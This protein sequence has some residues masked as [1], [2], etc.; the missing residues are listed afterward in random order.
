[1]GLGAGLQL[2]EICN[3]K[4]DDVMVSGK[5][6][7]VIQVGPKE[8]GRQV[9]ISA[10]SRIYLEKHLQTLDTTKP[11]QLVFFSPTDP[12]RP[13][14]TPSLTNMFHRLFKNLEM[15]N[16]SFYSL[17][18]THAV[19]LRKMGIDK[20]IIRNQLGIRRARALDNYLDASP[21]S[22]E[23]AIEFLRF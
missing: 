11:E 21:E 15:P 4:L 6:K 5:V 10:Q 18:K 7:R 2:S 23:L 9:F 22:D 8:S 20:A 17:R 3:L 14:P 13:M 12:S 19:G 16:L 1:M